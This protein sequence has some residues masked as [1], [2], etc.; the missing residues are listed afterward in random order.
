MMMSRSVFVALFISS[1]AP[2]CRVLAFVITPFKSSYPSSITEQFVSV[3]ED[4]LQA[5]R[6]HFLPPRGRFGPPNSVQLLIG[7]IDDEPSEI[8]T[9][10]RLEELKQ[11]ETKLASMLA[12]VRREKLAVLRG[13]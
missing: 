3:I 12:S 7:N 2:L 1:A 10:G 5:R 11:E 9:A 13:K 6:C 8:P 4:V